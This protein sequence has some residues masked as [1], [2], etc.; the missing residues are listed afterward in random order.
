MSIMPVTRGAFVTA[1]G[2]YR[3]HSIWTGC[4]SH[5]KPNEV[6]GSYINNRYVPVNLYLL[7]DMKLE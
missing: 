3:L 1:V 5:E 6:Y 2:S 7:F 4:L